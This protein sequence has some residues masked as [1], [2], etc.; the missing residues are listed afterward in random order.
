[1][2]RCQRRLFTT[3]TD[4]L[5][6]PPFCCR[7]WAFIPACL[8]VVLVCRAGGFCLHLPPACRLPATPRDAQFCLP[9]G[10]GLPPATACTVFYRLP[11]CSQITTAPATAG[12][13]SPFCVSGPCLLVLP[14]CVS[15]ANTGTWAVLDHRTACLHY[16]WMPACCDTA[17]H[18]TPFLPCRRRTAATAFYLDAFSAVCYGTTVTPCLLLRF[19]AAYLN[20]P[21][22]LEQGAGLYRAGYCHFVCHSRYTCWMF[23]AATLLR[24]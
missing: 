17:L 9:H 7:L 13:T 1:L 15:P 4:Y 20:S 14:A 2:R 8:T 16:A 23:P 18:F 11:A 3:G 22:R 12:A 21:F 6:L 24:T 10:W 19:S 5:E